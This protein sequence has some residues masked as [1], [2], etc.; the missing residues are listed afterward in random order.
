MEDKTVEYS[1]IGIAITGG[2]LIGFGLG[3][4]S[5][6]PDKLYEVDVNKD[7]KK[8]V[9]TESYFGS[10]EI[11]LRQEDGSLLRLDYSNEKI[12]DYAESM[13][14]KEVESTSKKN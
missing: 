10:K 6:K 4:F 12:G 3:S 8:D 5:F 11:F 14:E 13:L 9:I 2:F 1:R 7:Q